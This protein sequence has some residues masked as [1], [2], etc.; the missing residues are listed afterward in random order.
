MTRKFAFL[1]FFMIAFTAKASERTMVDLGRTTPKAPI[2][3]ISALSDKKALGLFHS[4]YAGREV[5]FIAVYDERKDFLQFQDSP[6]H[7]YDSTG[8]PL[9]C[10]E[11]HMHTYQILPIKLGFWGGKKA[12]SFQEVCVR[13]NRVLLPPEGPAQD[14]NVLQPKP[15][16]TC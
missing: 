5:V 9:L 2:S 11:P 4:C 6:R 14:F 12:V 8:V 13:G 10:D 15:D 16:G 7:L 3:T 1:L